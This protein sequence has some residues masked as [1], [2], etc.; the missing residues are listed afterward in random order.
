M[1]TVP[2][3]ID[4][5]SLWVMAIDTEARPGD[6]AGALLERSTDDAHTRPPAVGL[7]RRSAMPSNP[8]C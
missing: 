6:R 8:I 5:S 7:I 2:Y 1:P 3:L 4:V